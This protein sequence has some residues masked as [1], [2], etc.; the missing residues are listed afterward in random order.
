MPSLFAPLRVRYRPWLFATCSFSSSCNHEHG[1]GEETQSHGSP[2][3]NSAIDLLL[4][5][6]T[7][8]LLSLQLR[9]WSL[10]GFEQ[11]RGCVWVR[12][13]IRHSKI[14][15]I[16]PFLRYTLISNLSLISLPTR[17][18]PK[19]VL[20]AFSLPLLSPLHE[21]FDVEVAIV[22]LQTSLSSAR[23]LSPDDSS[24][25]ALVMFAET[26]LLLFLCGTSLYFSVNFGS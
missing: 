18:S 7:H 2:S 4:L 5:R 10:Q 14:T 3:A 16:S 1:G 6:K 25:T 23:S 8:M 21:T 15:N 11:R 19:N 24:P 17:Q 9:A 12:V 26:N 20:M 13:D 22:P